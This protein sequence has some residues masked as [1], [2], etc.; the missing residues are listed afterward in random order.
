MSSLPE[1]QTSQRG[2]VDERPVVPLETL[3]G[4]TL[5]KPSLRRLNSAQG[6]SSQ[7]MWGGSGTPGMGDLLDG[8]RKREGRQPTSADEAQPSRTSWQSEA[9]D[10]SHGNFE[11]NV[12]HLLENDVGKA[13]VSYSDRSSHG[14]APTNSYDFQNFLQGL[15]FEVNEELA[16]REFSGKRLS[17]QSNRRNSWNMLERMGS[18]ED[19]E[20]ALES[21]R[22]RYEK[23]LVQEIFGPPSLEY[24]IQP[25]HLALSRIIEHVFA[26][27]GGI[28]AT[29]MSMASEIS[30]GSDMPGRCGDVWKVYVRDPAG[31]LVKRTPFVA[32][33]TCLTIYALFGMDLFDALGNSDQ[34]FTFLIINTVVFILFVIEL[35]LY[36]I[37]LRGYLVTMPFVLDAIAVVSILSDTWF[38]QGDIFRDEASSVMRMARSSRVTRLARLARIA[39]FT[40]MIPAVATCSRNNR[41][42]LAK[43]ALLRRLWRVFLFL[44]PERTGNVSSFDM[45]CFYL[46]MIQNHPTLTGDPMRI[47]NLEED[48]MWFRKTYSDEAVLA[49]NDFSEGFVGTRIGKCLLRQHAVDIDSEEGTW[50]LTRKIGD[51]TALK[52]SVIILLLLGAL[53]VFDSSTTVEQAT[54]LG[55]SELDYLARREHSRGALMNLTDL[56]LNID[57]F[58]Q[59]HELVFLSLDGYIHWEDGRCIGG[60]VT[61]SGPY[62][63]I[64]RLIADA[65]WRDS[66]YLISCIPNIQ[67]CSDSA[68]SSIALIDFSSKSRDSAWMVFASTVLVIVLLLIFI[69]IM[70]AKMETLTKTLLNPLRALLDDMNVLSIL[71]LANVDEDMPAMGL[72]PEP[73]AKEL[74]DLNQNFRLLRNA[75]RSWSKYVP[76]SVVQRL[77][78]AGL[79]AQIGVSKISATILFCDLIGFEDQCVN[80]TPQ[81]V[82]LVLATALSTISEV[83]DRYRGTLLEFIGDEVLAVFNAPSKVKHHVYAGVMAALDIHNAI[84]SFPRFVSSSGDDVPLRCRCGVHTGSILAGNIGSRQRM[85]YGLLGDS[86]NLTARLKT[87]NSRYDT[88]TL[89]SDTV[90]A[91]EYCMRRTGARPVDVVAVKGKKKP[92][93]VYEAVSLDTQEVSQALDLHSEAFK[94]YQERSFAEAGAKFADVA[95]VFGE[96]DGP[97]NILM[98]RCNRYAKEPPPPDWDGVERLNAKSFQPG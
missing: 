67:D 37:G 52:I 49:W 54:A 47:S 40:R 53:S 50:R 97:S 43:V 90:V 2:E 96:S 94:L 22:K 66:D 20:D 92:T 26:T 39:R 42:R 27:G 74:A 84:G 18:T 59:R 86:I 36:A 98:S 71:E 13:L 93:V 95:K 76:P 14:H 56:C 44:D 3:M 38:L 34:E 48:S 51:R 6:M 91:D 58:R 10:H 75:I 46:V 29:S 19:T 61:A 5:G 17:V 83:I 9:S 23:Y 65:K 80:L 81:E 60:N 73:V 77:F 89:V 25:E 57:M 12:G 88:Q 85:K 31:K 35:L 64:Q 78:A 72:R 70:N 62:D 30:S 21:S 32:F 87:L 68:V 55:M 15:G 82:L 24:R 7:T 69:A 4:Q 33:F 45:K 16:V 28:R 1:L 63:H 79:E 11:V 41:L 8:G